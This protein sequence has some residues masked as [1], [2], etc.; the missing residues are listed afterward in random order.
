MGPTGSSLLCAPLSAPASPAE[1]IMPGWQH[2]SRPQTIM[3]TNN[4][5]LHLELWAFYWD[6]PAQQGAEPPAILR[7]QLARSQWM[8]LA[9][10]A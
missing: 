1:H 10:T 4:K 8:E 9:L 7:A 3:G 5:S 2:E 6:Q